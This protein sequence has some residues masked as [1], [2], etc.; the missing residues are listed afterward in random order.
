M[1]WRMGMRIVISTALS[2]T[3]LP[4]PTLRRAITLMHDRPDEP[5]LL[6]HAVTAARSFAFGASTPQ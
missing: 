4:A 6:V 1:T 5:S 2:R 3:Y